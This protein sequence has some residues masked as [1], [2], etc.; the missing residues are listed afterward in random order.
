[1]N[2]ADRHRKSTYTKN[3][4]L[5]HRMYCD[6]LINSYVGCDGLCGIR[7]EYRNPR[8]HRFATRL[9]MLRILL[10]TTYPP[11]GRAADHHFNRMPNLYDGSQSRPVAWA[12]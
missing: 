6:A 12:G 7:A 4:D 9:Q 2:R 1:M 10:F 5:T 3:E 8:H 11:S